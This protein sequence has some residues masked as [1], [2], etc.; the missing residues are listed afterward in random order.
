MIENIANPISTGGLG[1]YFEN[2]VQGAFTILMLAGGFSPCLPTWPIVKIKFQGKYQGF[3][4]DDMIVYCENQTTK[5]NAKLLAQIKHTISITNSDEKF[6]E[7]IAS[8]WKDFNNKNIFSLANKDAIAL[9]TGPLSAT[10]TIHV[11]NLLEQARN[12]EDETDFINRVSIS[13]FSSD[14]Q[15]EK[16]AVFKTQLCLANNGVALS[17]MQIWQFL[18]CFYLLIYDLDIKGVTLSLLHTIIQQ[19]SPDDSNSTWTQLCDY[20]SSSNCRAG[21]I[22]IDSI[23]NEISSVFTCKVLHTIPAE[24][25]KDTKQDSTKIIWDSERARQLALAMLIGSWNDNSNDDKLIV[26]QLIQSDYRPWISNLREIIQ[27]KESPLSLKNGVWNINEKK[28]LFITL[29]TRVFDED[30]DN[31]KNSAITVLSERDPKFEL[32]KEE[33]FA[34]AVYGKS[35]K[36]SE[37]IRKG[38]SEALALV[39][40]HNSVLRNCSLHKPESISILSVRE[41]LKD[42]D[43]VLWASLNNLLPTL[44]EAAPDEFLIAVEKSLKNLP[45]PFDELF[46]QEGT[47]VTGCTYISGLLWA[48]ET[49]AWDEQYLTRVCIIL[50]EL[51]G[52]DP[53]GSWSNRPG[54]SLCTILM[55]WL[56]QTTAPFEKRKTAVHTIIKELP[57][58]G[59]SLLIGL[60]PNQ[61]QISMGSHKPEWRKIIPEDWSEKISNKE[62]WD[63]VCFY[64]LTAVEQA[65][66][67]LLKLRQLLEKIDHLPHPAFKK[68][69]EYITSEYVMNIPEESR[70]NLW[71]KLKEFALKHKRFADAKWAAPNEVI[72]KVEAAAN[73]IEPKKAINLN[74]VLFTGRD[75]DFYEE[76][77]NWEE[78][79][80]K[81]EKRRQDAVIAVIDEAGFDGIITFAKTVESPRNL[82]H[83]LGQLS[84]FDFDNEILP[85]LLSPE[86]HNIYQF[87]A[88]YVWSRCVLLGWEWID[89]I[90]NKEWSDAQIS[91]FFLCLPPKKELWVRINYSTEA[92]QSI[93]WQKAHINPFIEKEN[94]NIAIDNLLKHGRPNAALNCLYSKLHDKKGIDID[95]TVQALLSAV[96]S[97]TKTD[98]FDYYH[99]TKIINFL[100]NHEA[101]N[102]DDLFKIEWAYVAL[103]DGYHGVTP[104]TLENKLAAD[105]DFFCQIISLIYRPKGSTKPEIEATEDQKAIATNAWK[106]LHNW[107]TPPGKQLNGSFDTTLFTSWLK[108]VKEKSSMSGHLEIALTHIGHCL[109]YSPNDPDGFWLHI[110]VAKE[111]D[112]KNSEEMREGYCCEIYNSRGVHTI[113]PTGNEERKLAEIWRTKADEIEK[114]GFS[115]LATSLRRVARGYDNEAERNV[116]DH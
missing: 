17:D 109:Y 50:S 63:Q 30:L 99:T 49:L 88:S 27:P 37:S 74:K 53:G 64:S 115:R 15:R 110:A 67:D 12:A 55:P 4:T 57:N 96:S 97:D 19:Y 100:Q 105:P 81:F 73:I 68:L 3:E 40:N 43:W 9:I 46:A 29:A 87:V 112:E 47:G 25:V 113:D 1:P 98:P 89:K 65:K 11:R 32:A 92:V 83:S 86:N 21:F 33:R 34:A 7:V 71:Q 39:G 6:K 70:A 42:A 108:Q 72:Y 85:S 106:L 61:S 75:Y 114:A 94:I 111:L 116:F 20:I 77:E 36:F 62:Y 26:S 35:L 66:D 59:W 8:A 91:E 78:Q 51:A 58:V 101:T 38:L 48:L 93:Y 54:K 79:E 56:P 80:N 13:N 102:Q 103:L 2:Q 24:F 28:E 45:C 104:K 52:R 31:L 90:I 18:K 10:E 82:G 76:N 22:T 41:I 84:Q 60:L 14:Q 5:K 69:L 44:A 23:P 16:L 95:R 107:H